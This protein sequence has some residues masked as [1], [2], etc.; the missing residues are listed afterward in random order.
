MIINNVNCGDIFKARSLIAMVS[1]GHVSSEWI[2]LYLVGSNIDY[3]DFKDKS[4]LIQKLND[5]GAQ[6]IGNIESNLKELGEALK[7][8]YK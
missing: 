8:E 5:A 3:T 1:K 4:S 7:E 6:F 2:L